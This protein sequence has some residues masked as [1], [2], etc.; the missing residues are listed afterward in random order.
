MGCEALE[1]KSCFN[2][3]DN[4]TLKA[5]EKSL[6]PIGVLHDNVYFAYVR[7]IRD[8][9]T[10][11]LRESVQSQLHLC[12]EESSVFWP[13]RRLSPSR[14]RRVPSASSSGCSAA[15]V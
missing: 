13:F 3:E 1:R 12:I 2:I 5:V 4:M 9:G 14:S 10:P 15:I 7:A 11:L 6:Q 8:C